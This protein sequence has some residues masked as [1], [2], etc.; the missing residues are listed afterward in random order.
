MTRRRSRYARP[1]SPGDDGADMD[2]VAMP[3]AKTMS[4]AVA[5]LMNL[6][7]VGTPSGEAGL[8]VEE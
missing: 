2:I 8:S 3:Q 5:L 4:A 6:V 7:M 1:K